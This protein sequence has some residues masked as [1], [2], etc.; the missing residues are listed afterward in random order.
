M[1]RT[2]KILTLCLATD[3]RRVL[4]GMKKRGFGANR[5]NGFGGKLEP[6]ES[7]VDAAKREML[8]E[9]GVRIT[10][11][12]RVGIHEF[13]F[14]ENPEILEVH[15]FRV[16]SFEGEPVETE[17]MRPQWFSFD[18]IPY[19]EMWPDD[20]YWLPMFLAGKKFRGYF[21]FGEGDSILEKRLEEVSRFDQD[22]VASAR[23]DIAMKTVV[24]LGASDKPQRY[25]NRALNLLIERGHS[26]VP[27]NPTLDT[28]G[29]IAVMPKLSE[30][31]KGPDVLTIYVKSETS[32]ALVDDI[33][34]LAPKTVIFNPGAENPDVERML[35][36]SGIRTVRTCTVTLLASGSFEACISA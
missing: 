3:G 21:L 11:L 24:I 10:S 15:V 9:S 35:E 18:D 27:V 25:S 34:S 7:I 30:V 13:E 36:L 17:E 6:D 23:S 12:E 22:A 14:R 1:I 31:S 4:L 2:K 16:D 32:S 5:W 26:V 29:S 33:V 8:E 20:A 19:A 28:I